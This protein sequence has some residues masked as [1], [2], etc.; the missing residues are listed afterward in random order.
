MLQNFK[1]LFYFIFFL[2][3][4][5]CIARQSNAQYNTPYR[6]SPYYKTA[7]QQKKIYKSNHPRYEMQSTPNEIFTLPKNKIKR[8]SAFEKILRRTKRKKLKL[9]KI[10]HNSCQEEF[11]SNVPRGSI[12]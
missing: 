8:E 7:P 5:G 12:Q 9:T 2:F 11:P 3:F 4:S 6:Y 1:K 10:K